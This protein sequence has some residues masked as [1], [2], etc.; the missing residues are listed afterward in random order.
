MIGCRVFIRRRMQSEIHAEV[1]GTLAQYYRY[2]ETFEEPD[3]NNQHY[4]VEGQIK[5]K[6]KEKKEGNLGDSVEISEKI[7]EDGRLVRSVEMSDYGRGK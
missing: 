7:R 5:E 4:L 3:P 1:D 6:E 2:M